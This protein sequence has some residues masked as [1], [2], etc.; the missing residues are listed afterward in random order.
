MWHVALLGEETTE[1]YK[2]LHGILVVILN[3]IHPK[4]DENVYYIGKLIEIEQICKQWRDSDDS[5]DETSA[6]P[7]GNNALSNRLQANPRGGWAGGW[8]L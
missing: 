4:I 8:G 2:K 7:P 1:R 5:L 6:P 3:G